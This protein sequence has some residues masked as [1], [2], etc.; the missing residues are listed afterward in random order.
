MELKLIFPY[1]F[2]RMLSFRGSSLRR[3]GNTGS[4]SLEETTCSSPGL[5]PSQRYKIDAFWLYA[6]SR[7]SAFST[8]CPNKFGTTF[9]A[10][11]WT[12]TFGQFC[13]K[14]VPIMY[15]FGN[16]PYHLEPFWY[17][18]VCTSLVP[19]WYHL[20]QFCIIC[21]WRKT[22]LCFLKKYPVDWD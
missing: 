4:S 3:R 11:F 5:H 15:Q 14:F 2:R 16:V 17:H 1:S 10:Y 6:S 22:N 7:N 19:V 18:F 20:Y 9:F 8:G 21:T 13:L 12:A